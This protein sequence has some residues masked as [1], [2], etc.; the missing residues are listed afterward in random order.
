MRERVLVTGGAGFIGSHVV[1][2]LLARGF[3]VRVFD[4]LLDQAHPS[5][6]AQFLTKH[7][8]LVVGDLRDRPALDAALRGISA[9]FHLGAIVGNGQSLVEIRRYVDINSVGTATLLEALIARRAELRRLVVASSMVVYGDGAYACNEHGRQP[10]SRPRERLSRGLWEPVCPICSAVVRPIAIAEDQALSPIS[11]YGIC[12]RDQEELCLQVGRAYRIPTI[13]LRLLCTYGSRQALGNP[14]TGVAA[15]WASRLLNGKP[16]VVFEDGQQ[17]RDFLH[18]SDAARAFIAALDSSGVCDYQA[19]NVG[20]GKTHT[21]Y[22][23][24]RT[25]G[26][27]LGSA[28]LPKLTGEYREGDIRHCFANLTRALEILK[29]RATTSLEDG[30]AELAGWA[31]EQ[32]PS[33][34]SDHAF[35]ELRQNG[36]IRS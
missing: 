35:D 3:D 2:A 29:W 17:Q 20:S 8:E 10:A 15:I 33:D 6:R 12:K 1:D 25:L 16:P 5:G 18:V 9:V 32:R 24:A 36:V 30:I 22:D 19:F 14:Y 28:L 13:A 7:A 23:L 4:N 21:I 31:A 34:R 11:P 27:S 26:A